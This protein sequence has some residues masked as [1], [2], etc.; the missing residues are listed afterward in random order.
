ML[1]VLPTGD[2]S[3]SLMEMDADIG[4]VMD[5][6]RA[7]FQRSPAE[8]LGRRTRPVPHRKY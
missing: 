6:I 8:D 7:V 2:Y 1:Q 4:K 3:D 5:A